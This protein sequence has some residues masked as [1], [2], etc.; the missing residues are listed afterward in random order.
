LDRYSAY[1]TLIKQAR[2]GLLSAYSG[3]YNELVYLRA[4]YYAAGTGR[5]ITRDTWAGDTSQPMSLNYWNYVH[6]NP[7]NYA[8]PSGHLRWRCLTD[9]GRIK[10]AES[11]V[12]VSSI[13]PLNTYTAIG[14]HSMPSSSGIRLAW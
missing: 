1:L 11:A 2:F 8:D 7:V 6:S 9:N 13:D 4:R 12:P 10:T 5:F 14:G 3:D